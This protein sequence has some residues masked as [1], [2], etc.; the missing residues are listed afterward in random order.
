[1]GY[2]LAKLV[3]IFFKSSCHPE[4]EPFESR[5]ES[6]GHPEGEPFESRIEVR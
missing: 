5:I 4:G 6:S 3:E 2:F 1:L